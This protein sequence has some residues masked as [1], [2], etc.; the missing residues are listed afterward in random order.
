LSGEVI[1]VVESSHVRCQTQAQKCSKS[2]SKAKTDDANG[3]SG[4]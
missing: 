3:A 1:T 4:A 2:A